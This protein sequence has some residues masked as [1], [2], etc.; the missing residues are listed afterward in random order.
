MG[1]KSLHE[2]APDITQN[3]GSYW[4]ITEGKASSETSF[5]FEGKNCMHYRG[6]CA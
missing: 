2:A 4:F 3:E 5:T 6:R 1:Y